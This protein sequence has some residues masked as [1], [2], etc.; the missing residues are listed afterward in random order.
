VCGSDD[1]A[2][3]CRAIALPIDNANP[4]AEIDEAGTVIVNGVPTLITRT[5][6]NLT[7]RGR[8]RDPGSDDLFLSWDWDAEDF[9]FP[10]HTTTYRVNPPIPDPFPSPSLQPRDVIDAKVAAFSFACHFVVTFQAVDDDGGVGQ[11]TLDVIVTGSA[12]QTRSASSWRSLYRGGGSGQLDHK[13]LGNYLKIAAHMSGVFNE[14]TDAST[15]EAADQVLSRTATAKER[16]DRQL[17]A[18]WLNFANGARDYDEMVDTDGNGQA[19]TA[20]SAV[21]AAAEAVRLNPLST[22]AQINAQTAILGRI[23]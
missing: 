19:D 14:V 23:N 20:F 7:F 5:A 12:Q 4:T 15:F 16:F 22:E 18:A 2:T 8:S 10:N 3:T 17:L 6:T 11:D 1:D 13:A 21:V 9:V